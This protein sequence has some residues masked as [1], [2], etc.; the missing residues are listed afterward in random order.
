MFWFLISWLWMVSVVGFFGVFF[1]QF[2]S[3]EHKGFKKKN[4]ILT[5][6]PKI[7]VSRI[8]RS[9]VRSKTKK[10]VPRFFSER[11]AWSNGRLANY[12][13]ASGCVLPEVFKLFSDLEK[14]F[15]ATWL[16]ILERKFTPSLVSQQPPSQHP[17][18]RMNDDCWKIPIF[19]RKYI[20]IHGG[21]SIVM[22]VFRG[23]LYFMVKKLYWTWPSRR[24]V[25]TKR[26]GHSQTWVGTL[27]ETNIAP[28]NRPSQKESSVP[29]IIIQVLC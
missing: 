12:W 14:P 21:F 10:K 23:V 15:R 27:P 16:V 5:S 8:Q 9:F 3:V 29:T 24:C 11:P 26:H 7:K 2:F 20:F 25:L 19:N 17:R 18:K 28:E 4:G 6:C 22:L 13:H 1:S